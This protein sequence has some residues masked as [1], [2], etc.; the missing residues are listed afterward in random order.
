VVCLFVGLSLTTVSAAKAAEL[1]KMP[2]GIW[3]QVGQRNH[4]LDGVVQIPIREGAI[5][6]AKMGR[7]MT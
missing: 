3:T 5:F 4:V 1:V 2:F 7:S 6:W